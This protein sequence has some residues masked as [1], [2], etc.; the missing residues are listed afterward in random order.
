[1][2][3][4]ETPL[5]VALLSLEPWDEVWRRNQHLAANLV[6]LPAVES[7]LFVTPP[8]GGL[9][10]R[11]RRFRPTTAIEV[12][13]PP[14][15]VPRR[16]GGHAVL[17]AWTRRAVADADVLWLNDP[18]AGR[19]VLG[20]GKPAVYDVTDD[21]RSMPQSDVARRRTVAAEDLLATATQ[22]VVCSQVL[23]DRWRARYGVTAEV[24]P[25]AVEVAAVRSAASRVLDGDGPHAVYVGTMHANRF[26][27]TLV[28]ELAA[29]RGMTVHLVG[30]DH[31]EGRT[32]QA[33][34]SAGVRFHGPVP[35]ENVPQWLVS[36]DVLI[37]PHLVDEFTLSLDAIKAH[38]YLATDRPVVA[39]PSCGFQSIAADGLAVADQAGFAAAVRMAVGSGPFRRPAPTSWSDRAGEFAAVLAATAEGRRRR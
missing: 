2:A 39:T 28:A 33:L 12:V 20:L 4:Q 32:R 30:P 26:D 34:I 19:G 13:T 27:A 7:I 14:L 6:R 38:E 5:R 21:W 37:C 11:A 35:A 16:I 10:I 1:M 29:H 23:A 22:T 31:L 15:I 25:N 18:A 8:T 24:V 17:A 36:A 3:E 9:A